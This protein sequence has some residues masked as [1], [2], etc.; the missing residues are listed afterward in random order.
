ME[1]GGLEGITHRLH[2]RQHH[3]RPNHKAMKTSNYNTN[4]TG[5]AKPMPVAVEPI[6]TPKT[7][8]QTIPI[9]VDPD[10]DN[11][12]MECVPADFARQ[13]ERDLAE[14]RDLL[15]RTLPFLEDHEDDGSNGFGW[16][17][18]ELLA[19]IADIEATKVG[20]KC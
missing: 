19:L 18:P 2:H 15:N 8:E 16:K 7:E 20:F 1:H 17:S 3:R 12:L 13:L 14:A 5:N 9:I 10:G 6:P 11:T 4:I